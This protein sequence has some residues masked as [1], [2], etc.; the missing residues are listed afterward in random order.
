MGEESDNPEEVTGAGAEAA[1]CRGG[2]G[3]FDGCRKAL[4]VIRLKNLDPSRVP[5]FCY[6][7]V[8]PPVVR[9]CGSE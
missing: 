1:E 4:V 7:I 2:K 8:I 6:P 5:F 9:C 3:E